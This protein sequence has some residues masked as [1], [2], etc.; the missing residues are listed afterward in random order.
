MLS[1]HD[2]GGIPEADLRLAGK[3]EMINNTAAS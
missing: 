2:V 3:I 1:T